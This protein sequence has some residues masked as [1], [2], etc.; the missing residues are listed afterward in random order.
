MIRHDHIPR[1]R[2][3]A[4]L[5]VI[6][7]LMMATIMATAYLASRDN[8]AAIGQNIASAAGARWSATT[9]LQL[10]IAIFQTETDWR[11]AHVNG[12]LLDDYAVAAALIDLDIVDIVTGKAPDGES[13]YIQLTSTA[14]VD[15][16]EQVATAMA[17]VPL[18][19]DSTVS[20]DL[21]EFAIFTAQD[22]EL[23]GDAILTRWPMA[24]LADLGLRIAVGTPAVDPSS[25]DLLGNAAVIDTTVYHD[26]GAS[27]ALIT[28]SSG[29]SVDQVALSGAI[30][31]PAAPDPGVTEPQD[32]SP[33][34]PLNTLG[35][36][37]T[38]NTDGRWD[39]VIDENSQVTLQGDITLVT[40][41]NR[42]LL[43][44]TKLFIDGNVTMVVFG[45]LIM[46]NSAIE[47]MPGSTLDMY[48]RGAMVLSDS[49]IGD[50]R[51]DTARDNSGNAPYMD[52]DRVQI[53]SLP[54]YQNDWLLRNNSVVKASIYAPGYAMEIANDSAVYGR[55]AAG[56]LR[57]KDQGALFYD[58][59]LDS[60]NGYTNTGSKLY[61]ADGTLIS[62]LSLLWSLNDS[63]LQSFA[64][65]IGTDVE[66]RGD[67]IASTTAP[68]DVPT[69]VLP[70]DPT[71]RPVPVEYEI[72]SFGTDVKA[73]EAKAST[74]LIP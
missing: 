9:G 13:E 55:L 12:K 40:D 23:S 17:Y 68:P 18:D 49:Y 53:Y 25:I 60:R 45:D 29:S 37:I 34:A 3:V 31:M 20:V 14:T 64:D 10:G 51:V 74:A 7:S 8:S 39:R 72:V 6:V 54:P 73:W 63:D 33:N 42:E 2:G 28:N 5:L 59:S 21:S 52:P 27:N 24:P 32:P 67:T 41:K 70:G 69:V 48:V 65:A 26:P 35:Q 30:P 46:D 15:G 47:L 57:I 36:T 58:H 43:G 11:T 19:Y 66:A 1:R 62:E 56:E 50:E 38:Y 61:A 16:V 44:G 4:M 22:L 71:P